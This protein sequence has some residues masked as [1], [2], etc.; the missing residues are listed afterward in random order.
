M[1][2]PIG[3]KNDIPSRGDRK[4]YLRELRIKADRGDSISQ[5]ALL[6]LAMQKDAYKLIEVK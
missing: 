1:A 2:R 6:F 5:A 4:T 3:A